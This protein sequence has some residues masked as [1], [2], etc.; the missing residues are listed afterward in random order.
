M[1]QRIAMPTDG[2]AGSAEAVRF[3]ARLARAHRAEIHLCYVVD[4][5]LI[6]R[7]L[8]T[9]RDAMRRELEA[10]GRRALRKAAAVCR[11]A[12]VAAHETLVEG[13]LIKEIVAVAQRGRADLLVMRTSGRGPLAALLLGS[14]AHSVIARAPCPV[15]L[16]RPGTV[17]RRRRPAARA[18]RGARA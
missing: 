9:M 6:A 16:V 1:F 14:S 17:R 11:Q 3:A 2:G 18:P 13:D 8:A 5:A 15:L 7:T 10:E 4:H 12:G